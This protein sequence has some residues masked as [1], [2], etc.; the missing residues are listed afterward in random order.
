YPPKYRDTSSCL[1]LKA[2]LL[3][4]RNEVTT[5]FFLNIWFLISSAYASFL[6]FTRVWYITLGRVPKSSNKR[7]IR[8][9]STFSLISEPSRFTSPKV[10]APLSQARE[11]A[12]WNSPSS[13]SRP[14]RLASRIVFWVIWI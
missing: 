9:S 12:V 13:I 8:L 2:L 14:S 5:Y 10:M 3:V 11:Q 6:F 7:Y 1:I 4:L